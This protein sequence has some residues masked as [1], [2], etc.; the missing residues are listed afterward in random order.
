MSPQ[1]TWTL[2]SVSSQPRYVTGQKS[3]SRKAAWEVINW[4]LKAV[5]GSCRIWRFQLLEIYLP[6]GM[7][8]GCNQMAG[9]P[10]LLAYCMLPVA[11]PEMQ[12]S[13]LVTGL[14]CGMVTSSFA[15]Y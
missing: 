7:Q 14:V 2:S 1:P 11:V 5:L 8:H 4:G 13:S 10:R 12:P 6:Q 3:W 9:L 15:H